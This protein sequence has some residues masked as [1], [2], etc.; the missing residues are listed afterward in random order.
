M[1]EVSIKE[2]M[3]QFIKQSKQR[4]GL[5]SVQLEAVWEEVMGVT[6]S[7]YTD[8]ISIVG[9]TLFITTMVGPLKQELHY[10]RA[11]IIQRVNEAMGESLIKEVVIQ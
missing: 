3:E 5:R 4:N 7:K 9:Q 1:S 6:I 11:L 8:K 10:Q 2:A